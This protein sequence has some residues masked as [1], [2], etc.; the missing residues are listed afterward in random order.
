[1]GMVKKV[2]KKVME[3]CAEEKKRWRQNFTQGMKK[4]RKNEKA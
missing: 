1:M 2:R 3:F 4:G